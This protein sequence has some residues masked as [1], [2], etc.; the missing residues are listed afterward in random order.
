MTQLRLI[1]P[2]SV[3]TAGLTSNIPETGSEYAANATYALGTMVVN[4]GGANPTFRQYESLVSGNVGNPLT[5]ETKWLDSGATNRWA[6]FDDVVGTIT[7]GASGIDVS[8]LVN[9]RVDGLAL[10]NLT[11]TS[12]Q[13]TMTASG[14]TVYDQTFDLL[15]D[16]FITDWFAYFSE[17]IA[18]NTSLVLTEL[19]LYANP[20]IRV[21]INNT[22]GDAKCGLMK[23]GQGRDIGGTQYG[24]GAGINDYS[25]KET[26][27]NFGTTSLTERD[28]AKRSQFE[29]ITDSNQVDAIYNILADLRATPVVW[30]GT[31]DYQMTWGFGWAKT[32]NA[33]LVFLNKSKI[34]LEMEGLI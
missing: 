18:Y 29:L 32:W 14:A 11:A 2:Y 8:V 33:S 16:T 30:I 23:V 19:P 15:S 17:D 31:K 1:R 24:A 20:T 10:F 7:T 4:V 12:V 21:R 3:T 9:G 34:S 13:V 25:K 22:L 5:D 26:D 27:P 28:F 6:M